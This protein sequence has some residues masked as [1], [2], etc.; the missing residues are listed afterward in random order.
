MVNL[1]DLVLNTL[2]ISSS[3]LEDSKELVSEGNL[4]LKVTEKL[5]S[6]LVKPT[7]TSNSIYFT[8]DFVGKRHA[9]IT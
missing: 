3:T 2:K 6:M 8:L 4:V 9:T 5:V 1:L 7:N